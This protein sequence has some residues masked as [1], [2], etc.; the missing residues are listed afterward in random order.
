MST[1]W[2]KIR[3]PLE[4]PEFGLGSEWCYPRLE[5]KIFFSFKL[6]NPTRTSETIH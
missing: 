4:W 5:G 2:K 6:G 1:A 3:Y